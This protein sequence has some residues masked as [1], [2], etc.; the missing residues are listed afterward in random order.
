MHLTSCGLVARSAPI[1]AD[2]LAGN[3]HPLL[4]CTGGYL[5]ISEVQDRSDLI[6]SDR[7]RLTSPGN[8]HPYGH[9]GNSTSDCSNDL[10]VIRII[11]SDLFHFSGYLQIEIA[12]ICFA[13]HFEPVIVSLIFPREVARTAGHH[14]FLW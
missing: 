5:H 7:T 13:L 2:D 4:S 12:V 14:V 10:Y 8:E 1:G 9:T 6:S 3:E 11:S